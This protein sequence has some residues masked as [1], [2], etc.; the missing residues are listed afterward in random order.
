MEYPSWAP[1]DLVAWHKEVHSELDDEHKAALE[2]LLRPLRLLSELPLSARFRLTLKRD[3]LLL[4]RFIF[5]DDAK[6]LW[7]ILSRTDRFQ[8]WENVGGIVFGPAHNY[9]QICEEAIDA[10]KDDPKQSAREK[11]KELETIAS[12]A[13]ELSE[14]ISRS[15]YMHHL[16]MNDIR[17]SIDASIPPLSQEQIDDGAC[18]EPAITK[19]QEAAAVLYWLRKKHSSDSAIPDHEA[20]TASLLAGYHYM[21]VSNILCQ[22][23]SMADEENQYAPALSKPRS[24][25]AMRQFVAQYLKDAHVQMFGSPMWDALALACTLIVDPDH[26]LTSD[27]VRPYCR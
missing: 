14:L 15:S 2:K 13:R 11:E 24:A 7:K 8:R 12:K 10:W 20:Q 5:L 6:N 17:L 19:D 3:N 16:R 4:D 22:I 1:A 27:D 18:R 9:W 26:Q 21:S 23:A 25:N